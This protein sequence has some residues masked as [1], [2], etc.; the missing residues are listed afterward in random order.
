VYLSPKYCY[1][2]Q[3]KKKEM[4]GTC[5]MHW[6]MRN[7]YRILVGKPARKIPLGDQGV[8]GRIRENIS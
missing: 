8:D 2:D 1:G 3:I 7:E 5:S 4:G 6:K